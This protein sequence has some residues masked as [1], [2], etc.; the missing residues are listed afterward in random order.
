MTTLPHQGLG[1]RTRRVRAPGLR[2]AAPSLQNYRTV[3]T[4]SES[5]Y[6]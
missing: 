1:A 2:T 6:I 3:E 5:K 4:M